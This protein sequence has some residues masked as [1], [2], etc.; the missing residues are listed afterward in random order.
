MASH[1][2]SELVGMT[3]DAHREPL[4]PQ[5]VSAK[6]T[7]LDDSV[8]EAELNKLPIDKLP[9]GQQRIFR[10]KYFAIFAAHVLATGGFAA[11]LE[12][13][14]TLN[15]HFETLVMAKKGACVVVPFLATLVLLVPNLVGDLIPL[16]AHALFMLLASLALG[17]LYAAIDVMTYSYGMLLNTG[18]MAVCVLLMLALCCF[19][20]RRASPES[21]EDSQ[22][23]VHPVRLALI[24]YVITLAIAIALFLRVGRDLLTTQGFCISMATQLLGVLIFGVQISMDFRESLHRTDA[25]QAVVHTYL[26]LILVVAWCYN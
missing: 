7:E 23:L 26:A 3:L 25:E 10:C 6:A 15:E 2:P 14:P 17:T 1:S 22:R 16:I 11:M 8:R 20:L 21:E 12:L 5:D 9:L 13:V 18:F 19:T 24:A 4:A